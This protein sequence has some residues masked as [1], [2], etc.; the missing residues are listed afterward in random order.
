MSADA[1]TRVPPEDLEGDEG[2]QR[3]TDEPLL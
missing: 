3:L 1:I 2:W